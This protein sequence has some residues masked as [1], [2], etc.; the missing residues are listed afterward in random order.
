MINEIKLI[1]E[2][3]NEVLVNMKFTGDEKTRD[4][5]VEF[6]DCNEE[7]LNRIAA[8]IIEKRNSEGENELS[9]NIINGSI[10]ASHSIQLHSTVKW[11]TETFNDYLMKEHFKTLG[12]SLDEQIDIVAKE[13]LIYLTT[14]TKPTGMLRVE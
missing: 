4:V 10:N 6:D 12:K 14:I 8:K 7:G 9:K 1:S 3:N 5:F 2:E 13:V 11:I